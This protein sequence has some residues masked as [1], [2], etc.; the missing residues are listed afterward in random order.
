MKTL[1]MSV[2]LTFGCA[3]PAWANVKIEEV[4]SDYELRGLTTS[5]IH[6]NIMRNTPREEGK[7]VDAETKEEVTFTLG[8][9]TKDGTC[10]IAS[11]QVKLEIVSTFPRWV[12]Q[13][14]ATNEAR[15]AW[16]SYSNA[17]RGHEDGHKAI[18]V[19]A[20]N[21]V[22]TLIHKEQGAS[23]C[24]SL[25]DKIAKAADNIIAI[26]MG[27]QESFDKNAPNIDIAEN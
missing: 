1:V 11:D 24:A 6:E 3:I 22:D 13:E 2:F 15:K 16:E 14:R 20:A 7:I 23:T 25:K 12:D 17:L 21:A 5:E 19:K 26:A 4:N 8:Y 18:A 10:R 9:E 27:E